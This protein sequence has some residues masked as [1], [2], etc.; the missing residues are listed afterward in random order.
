MLIAAGIY[1]AQN[2]FEARQGVFILLLLT[3]ALCL[4]NFLFSLTA[5]FNLNRYVRQRE[6][7]SAMAF[8]GLPALLLLFLVFSFIMDGSH[9][10]LAISAIAISPSLFSTA[11]LSYHFYRFRQNLGTSDP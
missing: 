4:L 7:L 5:L 10:D 8:I 6:L 9:N 2:G 1:N 3:A 11:L